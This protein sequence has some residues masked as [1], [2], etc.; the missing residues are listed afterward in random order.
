MK[1]FLYI[2][3][4]L[5]LGFTAYAQPPFPITHELKIAIQAG[6]SPIGKL[7]EILSSFSEETGIKVITIA[8]NEKDYKTNIQ[9]W[10][11]NPLDTP[12]VIQWHSSI[13]L[14]E[15]AKQGLLTSLTDL[16][17]AEGLNV[18]F[19][20]TEKYVQYDREIWGIPLSYYHW[21]IFYK[22]S[23]L[24]KYG[25]PPATW[26]ELIRIAVKMRE[27]GIIPFGLAN[28]DL[29]PA[30]AWF[31]YL[32]MRINGLHFHMKLLSGK[33]SFYDSR[34]TRVMTE[35]KRAVDGN[36]FNEILLN[37][38]QSDIAPMLMRGRIGFCLMSNGITA[39]IPREQLDDIGFAPFPKI[40]PGNN[41]EDSPV[42]VFAMP[43]NAVNRD[44]ATVFLKYIARPDI[45]TKINANLGYLPPNIRSKIEG[46]DFASIGAKL[47]KN[48]KGLAQYFDRDTEPAFERLAL[49]ILNKFLKNGDIREY[50]EQ[51]EAARISSFTKTQ[52]P[53]KFPKTNSIN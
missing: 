17:A 9:R 50:S 16:W 43:R 15:F 39:F 29:W 20:N 52:R 33:I 12:D 23:I 34:V 4:G 44:E 1:N 49:P 25:I 35:L 38:E 28:K 26:N 14:F 36:L 48:A 42:D 3:L 8:R 40:V 47:I 7:R 51:M 53:S 31:D 6:P 22:K 2:L 10:L 24:K 19:I 45:Q 5:F 11:T 18:D 27:D 37:S 21:G 30:G 32:N 13:R 46:G 41:Y